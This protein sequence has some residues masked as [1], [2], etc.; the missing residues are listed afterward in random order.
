ML[1]ALEREHE[2]PILLRLRRLIEPDRGRG[3][4]LER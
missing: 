1:G 2:I 3:L 4:Y